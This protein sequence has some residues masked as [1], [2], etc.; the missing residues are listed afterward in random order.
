MI[1]LSVFADKLDEINIMKDFNSSF[2]GLNSIMFYGSNGKSALTGALSKVL[3]KPVLELSPK[4][5]N[6]FQDEFPLLL[7]TPISNLKELRDIIA[8]FE[9]ESNRIKKIYI[10]NVKK[11]TALI[12][13]YK[14]SLGA[15]Y[16]KLKVFADKKEYPVVAIAVSEYSTIN[17]WIEDEI[18]EKMN[19]NVVGDKDNKTI[20]SDWS[21]Y[22]KEVMDLFSSLRRLPMLTIFNTG[23]LHPD[24]K[25]DLS[26]VIPNIASGQAQRLIIDGLS[27]MFRVGLNKEGKHIVSL[28]D[29][30]KTKPYIKN[31]YTKKDLVKELDVSFAPEKL[32]QYIMDIRNTK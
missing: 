10:A 2:C 32:W 7:S 22:K 28:Y 12:E 21:H 6:N 24:D 1:K 23:E 9:L 16:D 31:V 11:D 13:S 19:L 30:S 14:K 15:E 5:D 26:Q 27:A 25:K 3:N 18:A 17:S 4:G 29:T 20:G 8:Q